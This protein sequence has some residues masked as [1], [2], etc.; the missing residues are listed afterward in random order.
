[1]AVQWDRDGKTKF[2]DF[3]S[4][5]TVAGCWRAIEGDRVWRGRLQKADE[6]GVRNTAN[7]EDVSGVGC[8]PDMGMTLLFWRAVCQLCH[9]ATALPNPQQKV[10]RC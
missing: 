1:M 7:G 10:F 8:C 9:D 3:E 2:L 4:G 6:G 5:S